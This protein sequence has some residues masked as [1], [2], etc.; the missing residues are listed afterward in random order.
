MDRVTELVRTMVG[1]QEAL[2]R[3]HERALR[4]E[5]R[6]KVV[7][8]VLLALT[9]LITAL[10]YSL[11]A[12]S[13][14][15]PPKMHHPYAALVRLDGV[16]DSNTRANAEKVNAALRAAF[17]D[18]EARGVVLLINSPGG[19]PVQ[20]GLIHDR[21][22]ELRG[23]FPKKPVWAIGEDMMTSG[24]YYVAVASDHV[25][26]HPSTMTGSIGVIMSG[27]GLDRAIEHLGIDRRVITAG[28]HKAR[29]DPF[30]PLTSGD[31]RKAT[32]LLHAIHDQFIQAVRTGRGSR[33]KGDPSVLYSGDYWTGKEALS[34]GLVDGLCDLDSLLE[35]E[36]G[37]A[38]FR[39]YTSPPS[40]WASLSNSFGIKWDSVAPL[41][42]SALRPQLLP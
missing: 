7:R 24:A 41:T 6:W 37:V 1:S 5:Q 8:A 10:T 36:F 17:E 35:H 33:L 16:I 22:L 26:V 2:A 9:V 25:C 40:V 27:W 42:Q 29:L 34:M 31:R 21:L 19:S 14:V 28:S 39:D 3:L 32:L 4:R 23:R 11:G 13:L 20:S 18:G 30:R 15:S 12:Q 38:E